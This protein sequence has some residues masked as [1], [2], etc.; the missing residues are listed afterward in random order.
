MRIAKSI[1]VSATPT[2]DKNMIELA[3]K[4]NTNKSRAVAIA[5]KYCL[6]RWTELTEWREEE[7]G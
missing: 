6:F 3:A 1:Q 2:E 7:K 4:L 5:V